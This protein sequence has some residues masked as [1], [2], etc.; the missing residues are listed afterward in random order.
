MRQERRRRQLSVI[1][2]GTMDSWD[3]NATDMNPSAN[4][5]SSRSISRSGSFDM[6]PHSH[7]ES[8]RRD[9]HPRF[10]LPSLASDINQGTTSDMRPMI[11][12]PTSPPANFQKLE[13]E[14]EQ[15]GYF[16]SVP[17]LPPLSYPSESAESRGGYGVL[18][19]LGSE[20]PPAYKPGASGVRLLQFAPRSSPTPIPIPKPSTSYFR[21]SSFS[22]PAD[23]KNSAPSSSSPSSISPG[24]WQRL[25]GITS[26]NAIDD[27]SPVRA[28]KMNGLSRIL[29]RRGSTSLS[30]LPAVS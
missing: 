4:W 11:A 24:L 2:H 26:R 12:S 28:K 7:H 22:P 13:P 6:G 10:E 3:F 8:A 19:R 5:E 18:S 16:P 23:G 20:R 25:T 1:S 21:K 17:P 14:M 9:V 30:Q 27:E 15:D 29:S